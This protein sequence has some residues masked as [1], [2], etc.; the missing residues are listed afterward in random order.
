MERPKK[1]KLSDEKFHYVIAIVALSSWLLHF[2]FNQ[3]LYER[4][5]IYA[6]ISFICITVPLYVTCVFA[7]Y[8]LNVSNT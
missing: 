1:V 7:Y 3:D 8:H 4:E 2:V 5:E 6:G